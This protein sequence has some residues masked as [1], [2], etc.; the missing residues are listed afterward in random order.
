M[1]LSSLLANLLCPASL[2]CWLIEM[3]IVTLVIDI[4][5]RQSRPHMLSLLEMLDGCST[6]RSIV[7]LSMLVYNDI[8]HRK[9]LFHDRVFQCVAYGRSTMCDVPLSSAALRKMLFHD[10]LDV[11]GR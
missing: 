3:W 7:S 11:H 1:V 5:V 8:A 10:R 4:E 6:P 2:V 9:P